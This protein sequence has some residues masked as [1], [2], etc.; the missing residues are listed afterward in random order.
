MATDTRA[1]L[2]QVRTAAMAD[3]PELIGRMRSAA[4]PQE[5]L[6]RRSAD[7]RAGTDDLPAVRAAR[8]AAA[9]QALPAAQ[10]ARRDALE[11]TAQAAGYA[12]MAEAIRATRALPSRAAAERI[13]VG[14]STVNRWRIRLAQ[15]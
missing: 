4:L 12:S 10:Q 13:G 8:A 9:R 6:L 7:A 15:E 3:D 11:A 2:S 14:A 1:A 5:E